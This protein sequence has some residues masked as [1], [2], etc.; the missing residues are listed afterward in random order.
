MEEFTKAAEK[1]DP[2]MSTYMRSTMLA[3]KCKQ[4]FI[5]RDRLCFAYEYHIYILDF[6]DWHRVLK[7]TSAIFDVYQGSSSGE[8]LRVVSTIFREI[9]TRISRSLLFLR[10]EILVMALI[11]II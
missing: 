5:L 2:L 4:R 3:S 1:M 6:R 11:S 10:L 7:V 8:A 9:L